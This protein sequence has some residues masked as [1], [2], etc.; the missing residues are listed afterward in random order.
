MGAVFLNTQIVGL[1]KSKRYHG[2]SNVHSWG[3]DPERVQA[4][5]GAPNK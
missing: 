5:G 1:L 2:A 3:N 4:Y